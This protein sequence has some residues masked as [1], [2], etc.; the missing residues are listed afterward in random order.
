MTVNNNVNTYATTSA[1]VSETTKPAESTTAEK[2][3]EAAA[4][5]DG[6]V[7]EKSKET[8]RDSA[9]QIYNRDSI[10]AKLKADQAARNASMQSLVEKLLGKQ[11]SKSFAGGKKQADM[12]DLTDLSDNQISSLRLADTFRQAAAK[13]SPEDI[14]KAQAD[15]AEDGYWGV[16]QTS[17]R[18]V[19][20]AIALSGGDTGK[21]DEMMAAIQKGFDKATA[22]W[23]EKLPQISQD[24][25][26]AA[27]DKMN[28]WKNGVTTAEDYNKYMA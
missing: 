12:F 14:A 8:K 17:D 11:L 20:M 2:A 5:D 27:M 19:S 18:L 23:G 3:S 24:T 15:V 9:N 26:K 28:D 4:K 7:F 13:A 6:V 1:N 10:V 21:A 22:A 16:E 25:L